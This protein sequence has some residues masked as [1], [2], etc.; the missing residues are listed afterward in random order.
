M[1][2]LIKR[3]ITETLIKRLKTNP[4]VGLLG[5]RQVL[6][7]VIDRGRRNGQFLILG[8]ASRDLIRQSA[9]TL[10]G[11]ISYI[12]LTPFTRCEVTSLH[13]NLHWL[14][15]GYPRSILA[16]DEDTSIQWR[17]DY[18]RMVRKLT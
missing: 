6:R 18:D 12:E 1:H 10:A 15:G 13:Q 16:E 4:A 11:R 14:R 5:A 8:S 3:D 7:G 2:R 9:E 17:E